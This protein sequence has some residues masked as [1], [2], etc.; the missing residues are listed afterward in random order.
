LSSYYFS[1]YAL[2][3]L[4]RPV[5][6][7]FM[8]VSN[9]ASQN[10]FCTFKKRSALQVGSHVWQLA[11]DAST[12]VPS[13]GEVYA[14][15]GR[16]DEAEKILDQLETLSRQRYVSAYPVARI[17]IALCKKEE[18]FRWLEAAC[19]EHAAMMICLKV[20]PRFTELHS[21]PRFQ[22]LVRRVNLGE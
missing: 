14:A 13:L 4:G 5:A 12:I 10:A 7:V 1:A 18:A 21:E 16:S 17:H 15:A 6:F 22:D 3:E 19:D 8:L 9:N 2:S 20:D 11:P